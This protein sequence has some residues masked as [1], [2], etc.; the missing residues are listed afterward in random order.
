MRQ[1]RCTDCTQDS[2]FTDRQMQTVFEYQVLGQQTRTYACEKCGA[3][4][5]ITYPD[6]VWMLIDSGL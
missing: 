2:G 5:R 4:N 6:A 1:F 3:E